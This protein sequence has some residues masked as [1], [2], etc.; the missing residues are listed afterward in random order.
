[1]TTKA[2]PPAK[3]KATAKRKVSTKRKATAK[4][5][6]KATAPKGI[7][8]RKISEAV[9]RL[10]KRKATANTA[11]GKAR[12]KRHY[13]DKGATLLLSLVAQALTKAPANGVP[14]REWITTNDGEC[15]TV[16]LRQIVRHTTANLY[17]RPENTLR[18]RLGSMTGYAPEVAKVGY[19][20]VLINA[21][22]NPAI[23]P[24]NDD[25]YLV[26]LFRK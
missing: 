14:P 15:V 20:R 13:T 2:T 23:R 25:A 1:M 19:C 17:L 3:R 12:V 18:A 21:K 24:D 16:D 9:A 26:V 10:A 8:K 6:R 11:N 7:V 4:R 5:K 22:G